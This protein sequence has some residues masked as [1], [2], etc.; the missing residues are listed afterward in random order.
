MAASGIPQDDRVEAIIR[1]QMDL[2]PSSEGPNQPIL[3]HYTTQAGLLGILGSGALWATHNGFLND[4]SER[5][6]AAKMVWGETQRYLET[7]ASPALV[8]EISILWKEARDPRFTN[9]VFLTS[10][11]ENGDLLSQWRGYGT[12]QQAYSVG[13]DSGDLS[14]PRL[15]YGSLRRVIYADEVKCQLVRETIDIWLE[16][17]IAGGLMCIGRDGMLDMTDELSALDTADN[18]WPWLQTRLSLGHSLQWY[19]HSFKDCS[20][21]EEREWRMVFLHPLYRPPELCV[22]R[23]GDELPIPELYFRPTP[24]GVTP[25][26]EWRLSPS[27]SRLIKTVCVG[28]SG[29]AKGQRRAADEAMYLLLDRY[30]YRDVAVEHSEIPHR[31]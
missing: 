3:F 12:G 23:H 21:E 5:T 18:G 24:Y 30:D 22:D 31:W 25:Y 6:H 7:R 9:K 29:S 10:F 16:D 8:D 17:H 11:C 15:G 26:L 14:D 1:R 4:V 28:P 2:L 20:Y 27:A 13:F 19:E